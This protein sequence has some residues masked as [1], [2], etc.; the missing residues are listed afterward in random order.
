MK[1]QALTLVLAVALLTSCDSRLEEMDFP[2]GSME[3]TIESELVNR[4]VISKGS[5]LTFYLYRLE[6]H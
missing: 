2:S 4:V 6:S 1:L 5:F 3:P